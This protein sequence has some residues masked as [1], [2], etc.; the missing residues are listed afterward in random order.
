MSINEQREVVGLPPI[1]DLAADSVP[2]HPNCESDW[3][4]VGILSDMKIKT[5]SEMPDDSLFITGPG[6]VFVKNIG[7]SALR[8]LDSVIDNWTK[9]AT[10][11][12][13]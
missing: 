11:A 2:I 7:S 4:P 10:Y 6:S 3:K 1:D 13:A 8:T 5:T 9:A 12:L